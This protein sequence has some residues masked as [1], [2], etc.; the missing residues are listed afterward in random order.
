MDAGKAWEVFRE[1]VS[2]GF[3]P[4]DVKY[5]TPI[6]ELCRSGDIEDALELKR[7]M[8]KKGLIVDRCI[9]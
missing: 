2:M 1:M 6:G 8:E 3:V 9:Y 4:N 7:D 5:N